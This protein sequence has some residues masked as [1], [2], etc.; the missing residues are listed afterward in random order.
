MHLASRRD[1]EY[2]CLFRTVYNFPLCYKVT[3][4]PNPELGWTAVYNLPR[5]VA[6][7]PN[8]APEG[9]SVALSY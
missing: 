4:A 5:C 2:N 6:I 1:E 9:V 7:A 8:P 3:I